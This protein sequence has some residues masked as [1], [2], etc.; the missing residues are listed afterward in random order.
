MAIS[1]SGEV[2]HSPDAGGTN[3][4]MSSN[5]NHYIFVEYVISTI[6]CE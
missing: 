5:S 3:T 2:R 6:I 4:L 1:H